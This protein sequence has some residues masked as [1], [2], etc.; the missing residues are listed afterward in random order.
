MEDIQSLLL[1]LI[2]SLLRFTSKVNF[3]KQTKTKLE[4]IFKTKC[5]GDRRGKGPRVDEIPVS[6]IWQL[7]WGECFQKIYNGL[8]HK[9]HPNNHLFTVFGS[10]HC[11]LHFRPTVSE[12]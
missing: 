10:P 6:T 3:E 8:T 12:T 7:C 1:G 2:A 4:L 5:G 11:T 9:K